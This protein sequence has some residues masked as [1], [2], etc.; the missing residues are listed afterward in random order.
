MALAC[1][2]EVRNE[3]INTKRNWLKVRIIQNQPFK[4]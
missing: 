3:N 2:L 4:V 1:L